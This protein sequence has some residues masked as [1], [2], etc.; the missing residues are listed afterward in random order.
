MNASGKHPTHTLSAHLPI[1]SE[2]G[3]K[4]LAILDAIKIHP[5]KKII[6]K[7]HGFNAT[8]SVFWGN[9]R[10][11]IALIEKL[12]NPEDPLMVMR[13]E[14]RQLLEEKFTETYRLLHNFLAAAATLVD[15]TRRL[16]DQNGI[17]TAHKHEHVCDIKAT[18]ESDPLSRFVKDF[19]NYVLHRDR[20]E[21]SLTF[22]LI[23]EPARHDLL[24]DLEP[25][26]DWPKWS[27]PARSFVVNNSPTIRIS[28]F[29]L[30]YGNKVRCFGSKF[31]H[32]FSV[33][34]NE[35]L[36]AAFKLMRE[37]NAGCGP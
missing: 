6:D 19:R 33:Y 36:E 18:F 25:M 14:H 27:P 2:E 13:P 35:E 21:M 10:E 5:G 32:R 11:L 31:V 20:P 29:V 9:E 23:P 22:H 8:N 1:M 26:L 24:I 28:A 16:M 15:H 30:P 17:S 34:Y 4:R 3:R 7:L 37:W 12:E